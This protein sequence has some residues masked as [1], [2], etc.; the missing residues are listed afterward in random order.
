MAECRLVTAL[1]LVLLA[2]AT[3][4]PGTDVELKVRHAPARAVVRF[5]QRRDSDWRRV[6]R[7]RAGRTGQAHISFKL[8][9]LGP[10]RVRAV[11]RGRTSRPI[12]A[13]QPQL[14]G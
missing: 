2:P 8:R 12:V 9:R 7:D 4:V 11:A 13:A 10:H 5:E 6:G 14:R 3:A 1:T